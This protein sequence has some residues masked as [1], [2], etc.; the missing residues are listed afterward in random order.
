[1]SRGRDRGVA[2]VGSIV[3]MFGLAAGAFVWLARDVDR[4]I[5][6][7]ADARSIAFQ[8]ARAAAQSLDE[9]ALRAGVVQLDPPRASAAARDAAGQLLDAYRVSGAVTAVV[10]DGDR[11]TV[12]VVVVGR[13]T[14][15]GSAT[16]RARRGVEGPA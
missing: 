11:V 2:V 12:D 14:V 15:T 16:V 1:M 10:V 7:R 5:S 4:T 13:R 6:D 3:L 9:G 8:A